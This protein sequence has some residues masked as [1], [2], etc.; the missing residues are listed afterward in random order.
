MSILY[1]LRGVPIFSDIKNAKS[2]GSKY[3]LKGFHTHERGG[4]VGY[5]A[6]SSH[7]HTVGVIKFGNN[8]EDTLLENWAGISST[9][10]E[11][12]KQQVSASNLST[13]GY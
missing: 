9:N 7:A 11:S 2:W 5:M 12:K 8:H 3:G 10:V 1:K 13:R 4:R 6:G